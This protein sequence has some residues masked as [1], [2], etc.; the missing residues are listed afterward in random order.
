MNF[1]LYCSTIPLQ[2]SSSGYWVAF[3]AILI[4]CVAILA[5]HLGRKANNSPTV[6]ENLADEVEELPEPLT[7]TPRVANEIVRPRVLWPYSLRLRPRPTKR[8]LQD[9]IVCL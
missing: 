8:A 3:G 1:N 9:C 5:Y 7:E 4:I 6:H 2:Q